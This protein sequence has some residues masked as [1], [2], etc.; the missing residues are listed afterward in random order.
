MHF[1]LA[2][3]YVLMNGIKIW[4]SAIGKVCDIY[5]LNFV[6]KVSYIYITGVS[7]LS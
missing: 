5:V 4:I 1:W 2:A 6:L 7:I 3:I